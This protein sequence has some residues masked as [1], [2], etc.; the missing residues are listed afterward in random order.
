MSDMISPTPQTISGG[1]HIGTAVTL[2]WDLPAGASEEVDCPICSDRAPKRGLLAAASPMVGR[3]VV[4]RCEKCA[5]GVVP[6][7]PVV[8][9]DSFPEEFFQL[10]V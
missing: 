7:L 9:Y 1:A 10:Y 5:C 4:V 2:D 6:N 8:P 3:R